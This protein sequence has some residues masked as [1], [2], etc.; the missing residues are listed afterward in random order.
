[1]PLLLATFAIARDTTERHWADGS[2]VIPQ[3]LEIFLK[4]WGGKV[5][6]IPLLLMTEKCCIWTLSQALPDSVC[7][8]ALGAGHAYLSPQLLHCP[9]CEPPFMHR[10]ILA[11]LVFNQPKRALV[12]LL[13]I[14]LQRLPMAAR[15]KFKSLKLTAASGSA[16]INMNGHPSREHCLALASLHTM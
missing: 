2:T 15:I 9:S 7:H 3:N 8:T 6:I 4:W 12:A 1:M 16:L 10:G 13:L 11:H 5:W 14:N